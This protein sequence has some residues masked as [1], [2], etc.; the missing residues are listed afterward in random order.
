MFDLTDV[1]YVKRISI[2]SSTPG[3]VISEQDI[4]KAVDLLNRCLSDTPKGTILGMEKSF[5]LIT[6]GENH[7]VIQW[8]VYHIGFPRKPYWLED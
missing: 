2:G 6:V 7:A 3:E 8:M 1:H 4:Q 5:K